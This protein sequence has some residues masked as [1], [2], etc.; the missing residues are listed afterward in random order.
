MA[1]LGGLALFLHGMSMMCISLRAGFEKK[2]EA[3]MGDLAR[4]P[5][6][7]LVVG[8]IAAT[9]L[10]SST[11][12]SVLLVDFVSATILPFPATIP[13]FLGAG[14]GST[15]I[16]H[17][18]ALD[19]SRL[20]FI[21]LFVGYALTMVSRPG[22]PIAGRFFLGLGLVFLGTQTITHAF[23]P[24][25][26]DKPFLDLLATMHAPLAGLLAGLLLTVLMQ[27]S[28]ATIS[29]LQSL[30]TLKALPL[31]AAPAIVMGA[32]IGTTS[33]AFF[34]ALPKGTHALR[35]ALAG[36]VVRAVPAITLLPFAS[37]SL[38]LAT[39]MASEPAAQVAMLHTIFNV[40]VLIFMLPFSGLVSRTVASLI[41]DGSTQ[42]FEEN[43]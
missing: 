6:Q 2:L 40:L 30:V 13:V 19:L 21:F 20:T 37:V 34:V 17:M 5:I 22:L 36:L 26:K 4:S 1:I 42:G 35:A 31:S 38:V 10:Q 24:L 16:S 3:W 8:A 25:E 33:T 23:R 39:A 12:V 14:V 29:V 28:L 9:L 43:L 27:S 18:L 11:A 41:P 32:N 7:G 15:L